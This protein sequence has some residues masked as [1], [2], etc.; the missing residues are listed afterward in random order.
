MTTPT[1]PTPQLSER[2]ALLYGLLFTAFFV[3]PFYLSP[4]LRTSSLASRDHPTVIKARVRAVALSCLASTIVAVYVVLSHPH[5]PPPPRPLLRLF[6]I[7]PIRPAD[8][9]H[10]L[11]L[12]ALLF[13][14]PLYETVVVD[15]RWREW[16]W[17]A[18]RERFWTD[19]RGFRNHVVA[20]W[21]E[22]W[23]FRSLVIAVYLGAPVS[24][25]RIVFTTPLIFGAA[26]FHHLYEFV[27]GMTAGPG[28]R[29][30]NTSLGQVLLM[31]VARSFFQ[32]TYTTLFGF[33]AAFVYLRTGNVFASIVAH[34]FCNF[35][36]FPR[37]AGKVGQHADEYPYDVTPD[38]AQ[39][40][41]ED[42]NERDGGHDRMTAG[43][44]QVLR[45]RNLG[46]RWTVAYYLLLVVGSYGFYKLLWPLTESSNALVEF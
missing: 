45:P 35:M 26:H 25:A 32:F 46:T 30:H 42:G 43:S 33:F 38:V 34:T 12:L 31:G 8:C 14:G 1:D 9:L 10:T 15:G 11:A 16:T 40:K 24:P 28:G 5:P 13:A 23:V 41:R 6:A 17:D 29:I 27:R 36:G 4:T 7:W 37:V 44:S 3:A 22:E 2:T 19:W 20:P 18:F 21:A 39:G